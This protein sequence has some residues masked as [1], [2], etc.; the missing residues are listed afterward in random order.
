MKEIRV[1]VRAA[2]IC[3]LMSI[4]IYACGGSGGGAIPLGDTGN[5]S[6]VAVQ[7]AADI[8]NCPYGGIA[9][10]YGIDDNSNGQLDIPS[11][12]D[13]TEYICNGADGASGQNGQTALI[14]TT[15]LAAGD[16]NCPYG[17]TMMDYG[18]DDDF[19]GVLAITEVD[20]T[21]YICNGASDSNA[22]VAPLIANTVSGSR[23]DLEWSGML[24]RP[25]I[26]FYEIY[27]DHTYIHST[28]DA[29]T[30]A[31][32][33]T[34]LDPRKVYCFAVTGLD[35]MYN[36]VVQSSEVCAAT[37]GGHPHSDG[38]I[39]SP[40]DITGSLP[41]IGSVDTTSSYYH[42]TVSPSTAYTLSISNMSDNVDLFVYDNNSTFAD[43][44]ITCSSENTSVSDE[45][46]NYYSTGPDLYVRVSGQNTAAGAPFVLDIA[47]IS[48]Q[49]TGEGTSSAPVDMASL[50]YT[51]SVDT[52]LSF[53]NAAV[54]QGTEYAVILS[55]LT[56]NADLYVY[57]NDGT[58]S[59]LAC[60]S[61]FKT[62]FNEVCVITPSG[63][64]LYI[65][66]SGVRTSSGADYVL[67]VGQTVQAT[68]TGSY[69]KLYDNY[70]GT[71]DYYEY[72]GT[73]SGLVS[74]YVDGYCDDYRAYAAFDLSSLGT[75]V[76]AAAL[77][78][79]QSYNM[80]SWS[81]GSTP[82]RTYDVSSTIGVD[83]YATI[84]N[85]LGAGT[86]Y[87]G[88]YAV[89]RYVDKVGVVF[90]Q[91]AVDAINATS[92][93]FGVGVSQPLG[94]YIGGLG[95][96]INETFNLSSVKLVVE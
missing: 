73:R 40:M 20:D 58:F 64:D 77:V 30:L 41:Y 6:T 33:V 29:S 44:R 54:S 50:P 34:G 47:E 87:S 36:V 55:D 78:Y 53:Y 46:C 62:G 60:S 67:H 82:V 32:S 56:D 83:P 81:L 51:G 21:A 24:A 22:P 8:V 59:A 28:S 74:S 65:L 3:V 84:Y 35:I 23:I 76:N 39:A 15:A 5:P 43:N 9:L 92:G 89:D 75:T 90:N 13:G 93:S 61:V 85:D 4:G 2:L 88:Q 66:V 86:Q 95:S 19:D 57:D 38:S 45:Q 70:F 94:C 14:N 42:I 25:D 37:G 71:T 26:V 68:A 18:T 91:A 7:T 16:Q 27:Q 69:Y 48:I 12:V 63:T 10:D 52:T 96:V 80:G 49:G 31:Y 1:V 79:G 72:A 11:E 17:G